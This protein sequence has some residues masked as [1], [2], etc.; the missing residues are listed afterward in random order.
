MNI[1]LNNI[2]VTP[3]VAIAAVF[4]LICNEMRTQLRRTGTVSGKRYA[5]ILMKIMVVNVLRKFK[6]STTMDI[7]KLKKKLSVTLVCTEGYNV[8][9]ESRN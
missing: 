3:V 6:L 8:S 4:Y 2:I 5:E 9:L 7:Y 1:S